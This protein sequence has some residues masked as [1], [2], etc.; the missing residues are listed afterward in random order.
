MIMSHDESCEHG[1]KW[2]KNQPC[3]AEITEKDWTGMLTLTLTLTLRLEYSQKDAKTKVSKLSVCH[4]KHI[5]SRISHLG[6]RSHVSI[7]PTSAELASI[8]SEFHD[9]AWQTLLLTRLALEK[10]YV[11]HSTSFAMTPKDWQRLPDVHEST[12][13][14]RTLWWERSRLS[15]L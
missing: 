9:I 14:W 2:D 13:I 5:W 6:L 8:S 15:S 10:F 11:Y 7:H 1:Q 4:T 3:C 12:M